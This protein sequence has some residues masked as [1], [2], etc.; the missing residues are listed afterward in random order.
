M[1][2][3]V[4]F[5]NLQM[6]IVRQNLECHGVLVLEDHSMMLILRYH[7]FH[8][9]EGFMNFKNHEALYFLFT[10]KSF[11]HSLLLSGNTPRLRLNNHNILSCSEHNIR[12]GLSK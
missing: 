9:D 10:R 1:T 3:S 11:Q 2:V 7:C 4:A 5:L 8:A 12:L 6:G